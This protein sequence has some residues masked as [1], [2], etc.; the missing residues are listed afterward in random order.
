MTREPVEHWTRQLRERVGVDEREVSLR[1]DDLVEFCR[2]RAVSPADLLA[3]WED[4]PELLVRWRPEPGA[5]PHRSVESFLIH[6]G[7]NVFGD[8]TCVVG[9]PEGLA[10]QGP[11]FVR[12]IVP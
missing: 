2:A 12:H 4:F 8:T 9:W 11:Q 6:N 5:P 1:C 10:L 3:R 7:V